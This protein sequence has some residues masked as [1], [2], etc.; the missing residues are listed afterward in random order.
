MINHGIPMINHGWCL[1]NFSLLK[2]K[3]N[4]EM[5]ESLLGPNMKFEEGNEKKILALTGTHLDSECRS[6]GFLKIIK[7]PQIA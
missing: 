4:F 6:Y 2:S 5:F 1:T 7:N 3:T